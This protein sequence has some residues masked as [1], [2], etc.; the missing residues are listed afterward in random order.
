[1]VGRAVSLVVDK[2]PAHPSDQPRLVLERLSVASPNGTLVVQDLDLEV[3]G[4]EIVCV[5]GVQG[6][7]QTELTEALLG[8]Q[9]HVTGSVQLDGH[10]LVGRSVRKILDA[11]GRVA[12]PKFA[13]LGMAWQGYYLDTEGNT[14][15]VHQPD[16][17]A[18]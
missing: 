6:N 16:P 5:A 2:E 18:R 15:G 13:L 14:F 4:G 11:G 7:G 17:E 9:Q 3:A 8:L 1:M 10:E 12:M